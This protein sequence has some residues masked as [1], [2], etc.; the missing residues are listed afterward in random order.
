MYWRNLHINK[1]RKDREYGT[2]T[3]NRYSVNVS[4]INECSILC[5]EARGLVHSVGLVSESH[6]KIHAYTTKNCS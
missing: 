4:G 3:E 1:L 2:G 5:L 6:K